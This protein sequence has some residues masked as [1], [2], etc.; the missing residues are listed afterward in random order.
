ML[1][2]LETIIHADQARGFSIQHRL[3]CQ[4][5]AR[6]PARLPPS[7]HVVPTCETRQ[8]K[9]KHARACERTGRTGA[10]NKG[11]LSAR[12]RVTQD[13]ENSRS[14]AFP[15]T[16]TSCPARSPLQ[17]PHF[18]LSQSNPSCI[19]IMSTGPIHHIIH[20]WPSMFP[21]CATLV[22]KGW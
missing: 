15:A 18:C 14:C 1:R 6:K 13:L 16:T 12:N 3:A 17:F 4:S 7:F 19:S 20:P 8:T 21:L 5:M 2:V 10:Q 22:R 11:F 9:R